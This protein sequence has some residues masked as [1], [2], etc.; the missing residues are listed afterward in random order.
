MCPKCGKGLIY[1]NKSV[2]PLKMVLKTVDHCPV[3]NQKIKFENDNAPGMN[4]A[5]SVIIYILGFVLYELIWGIS[6]VDNSMIYAFLFATILVL[7]LQPWIMRI[8]KTIYLYL[9]IQF[10]GE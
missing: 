5:V 3:C 9:L 6:V 4:Y 1:K 10:K 2:F 8:S 7:L